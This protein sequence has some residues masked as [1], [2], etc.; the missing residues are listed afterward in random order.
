VEE[1]LVLCHVGQLV[2]A[3]LVF[4][5]CRHVSERESRCRIVQIRFRPNSL[6]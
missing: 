1:N 5:M 2:V 6:S 4:Q 3:Q